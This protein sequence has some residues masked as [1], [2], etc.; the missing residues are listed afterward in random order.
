MHLDGPLLQHR[1][2]MHS[3]MQAAKKLQR[4]A[5]NSLRALIITLSVLT[6]C[7]HYR[8][9][10][11]DPSVATEYQRRTTHALFW[12]LVQENITAADCLS[13]SIN[14]VRV[15][16]NLGYALLALVTLGIWMPME[17]EWRCGKEASP[18]PPI[19]R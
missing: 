17:I 3:T 2:G 9:A 19:F 15:T 4:P 10:V 13:N 7:Y 5:Q 14:G 11:P 16:T 18:S 6:G 8:V 1:R 12:G